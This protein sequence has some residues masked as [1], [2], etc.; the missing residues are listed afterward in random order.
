M[1]S[2]FEFVQGG[3]AFG[4]KVNNLNSRMLVKKELHQLLA[5]VKANRWASQLERI[6]VF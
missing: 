3:Y 5:P 1:R 6:A 4:E 2:C